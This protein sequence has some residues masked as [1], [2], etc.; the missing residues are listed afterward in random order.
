MATVQ[1]RVWKANPRR[2]TLEQVERVRALPWERGSLSRLAKEFGVNKTAI[3]NVRH[4]LS[5]KRPWLRKT[6]IARVT[7]GQER[8][9]LG[10]FRTPEAA[11]N[12]IDNFKRTNKWPRGAVYRERGRFRARLSLG[13]YDTRWAAERRCNEALKILD[14]AR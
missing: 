9:S 1:T 8:Y 14:A 3:W 5:Y 6:Y 11:Q 12:A 4:G 2:L 10:S 7:D 13:V